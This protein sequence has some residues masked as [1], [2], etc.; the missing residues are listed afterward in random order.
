MGVNCGVLSCT[1]AFILTSWCFSAVQESAFLSI[2]PSHS[3]DSG[4]HDDAA[5]HTEI[6]G[7]SG[8]CQKC[9]PQPGSLHQGQDPQLLL[10]HVF[11]NVQKGKAGERLCIAVSTGLCE[12]RVFSLFLFLLGFV[13]LFQ[14]DGQ[15]LYVQADQQLY[16][17]LYAWRPKGT[18]MMLNITYHTEL[19]ICFG[20]YCV[21][22][23]VKFIS[24]FFVLSKC[25]HCLSSSLSSCVLFATMSTM[26]P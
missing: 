2:F 23:C 18:W 1:I 11:L 10:P 24:N 13:A 12:Q 21:E 20:Q 3:G 17:L 25:R 16:Q 5:H 15:R 9:Q 7:Q 8:C 6:Q 14:P 26:S 19:Q 4:Q 22:C